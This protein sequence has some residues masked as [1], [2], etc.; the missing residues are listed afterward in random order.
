M[1]FLNMHIDCRAQPKRLCWQQHADAGIITDILWD[2]QELEEE[3]ETAK[4][5]YLKKQRSA[6][7]RS[8][9]TQSKEVQALNKQLQAALQVL[10]VERYHAAACEEAALAADRNLHRHPPPPRG[11]MSHLLKG[12]AQ[13]ERSN[14]LGHPLIGQDLPS[15]LQKRL[16]EAKWGRAL[17]LHG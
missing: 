10:D 7:D 15:M 12:L 16:E 1:P 5:A 9:G 6:R 13:P 2:M 8:R 4:Q 11:I 3:M 14:H 17:A